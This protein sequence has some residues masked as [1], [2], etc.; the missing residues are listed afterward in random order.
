M[1]ANS[2]FRR[3]NWQR[4]RANKCRCRWIILYPQVAAVGLE[5]SAH[6]IEA[7]TIMTWPDLP[8]RLASPIFGWQLETGFWF[9]QSENKI[10]VVDLS[11]SGQRT[12]SPFVL[13][14]VSEKFD[15][16]LLQ[17]LRID[18]E[19]RVARLRFPFD[20]TAFGRKIF[21][22]LCAQIFHKIGR[23]I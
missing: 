2:L 9:A 1:P 19:Q 17:K 5:D 11:Q 7:K 20:R 16:R 10:A 12:F 22:N 18:L 15:E 3:R 23:A 8:K 14:S 4:N 6:P 21:G 13:V